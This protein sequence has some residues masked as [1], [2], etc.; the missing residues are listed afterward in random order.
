MSK[1]VK[2]ILSTG[3]TIEQGYYLERFGRFSREYLESIS[4]LY[5]SPQDAEKIGLKD[6]SIVKVRGPNGREIKMYAKIDRSVQEGIVYAAYGAIINTI[7]PTETEAAATPN[8]K[9]IPVEVCIEDE[10]NED[11]V[12]QYVKVVEKIP[13][14]GDRPIKRGDF[15][16]VRAVCP[17]CGLL[18]DNVIVKM[19]G[20]EII[21][22]EE[23]CVI[24]RAKFVTYHKERVLKPLRRRENGELIE[25]DL[26]RA[27]DEAANILADSKYPLMYG[28][29]CTTCEAIRIGLKLAELIGAVVDNTSSVCHGP[30][31]MAVA[32]TGHSDF[33]L[34]FT[35]HYA[36]LVIFWGWN[37]SHAHPNF[38]YRFINRE[39]KLIQG[40]KGRKIIIIDV[41][42]IAP[43]RPTEIDLKKCTGCDLCADACPEIIRKRSGKVGLKIY[44]IDV[45]KCRECGLCIRIC[46]VDAFK[47][48]KDVDLYLKV[49]PGR[50]YELLTA[51]RMCLRDLEIEKDNVGGIDRELF[52]SF[53]E[54][55]RKAR[56]IVL[57]FGVGLTHSRGKFKNIEEAIK[58]IQELNEHTKAIIIAMRGHFNVTGSNMVFLWTYGAP[59]GIDLSKR[60]PR[61]IPGVTTAVDILRRGETDAILVAGADPAA[62]FP[63]DAVEHF[64]KVPLILLT[65]KLCETLKY[66][67]IIIPV[68]LSGI[69]CEGTAYRLDAIPIRLKKLVDPPPG[70]LTDY[71]ILQALY[72]RVSKLL[73]K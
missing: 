15:K 23:A 33:T 42:D 28:W 73:R 51:I 48:E 69:E 13:G 55:L 44:D 67:D 21:D 34:G 54:E 9:Q 10:T 36:D 25:I 32:E 52:Q 27:L 62:S 57:F 37:P 19:L 22:V 38:T 39:G 1:C 61:Y 53:C 20:E 29:S 11:I 41:R 66:A 47:Y 63:R 31:M 45:E 49:A 6:R 2:V 70:V 14:I 64:S 18:C 46:P 58:T 72:D 17:F 4:T 60:Y 71:E 26:E 35:P 12:E 7:V 30:T 40:R 16:R 24:G 59:F 8:Y 5:V 56:Y 68:A 50:D 3:R 65:P 43:L